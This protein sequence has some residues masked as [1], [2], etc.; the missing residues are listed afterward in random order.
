MFLL[1]TQSVSLH[2]TNTWPPTK[3]TPEKKISDPPAEITAVVEVLRVGLV[4]QQCTAC[5][6]ESVQV[7]V[8]VF[9]CFCVCVCVRFKV[10]LSPPRPVHL[11]AYLIT[12][13]NWRP[14]VWLHTV[15]PLCLITKFLTHIH[16]PTH[17]LLRWAR[18]HQDTLIKGLL[19]V[20]MHKYQI[21][22]PSTTSTKYHKYKIICS[23]VLVDVYLSVCLYQYATSGVRKCGFFFFNGL[24]TFARYQCFIYVV[25]ER[26]NQWCIVTYFKMYM[27]TSNSMSPLKNPGVS[28]L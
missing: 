28:T 22:H 5:S 6:L 17:T 9:A 26:I 7:C 10:S 13:A 25:L 3:Q 12:L 8:F 21:K 15:L 24:K 2:R 18:V 27:T 4:E 14:P 20:I 1:S 16:S 11:Q 19:V 23:I